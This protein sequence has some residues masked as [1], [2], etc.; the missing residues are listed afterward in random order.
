MSLRTGLLVGV[1]ALAVGGAIGCGDESKDEAPIATEQSTTSEPNHEVAPPSDD[2]D[3]D[4]FRDSK[5]L[6]GAS[7]IRQTAS[8]YGGEPDHPASV[9]EAF[10]SRAYRPSFHDEAFK[11]CLEGLRAR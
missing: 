3:R 11:G 8:E 5:Q 4:V 1:A 6:C 7:P 9:A 10:A 2:V